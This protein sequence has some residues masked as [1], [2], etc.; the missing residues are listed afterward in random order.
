MLRM[1]S[2]QRIISS[3]I[4]R[5]SVTVCEVIRLKF[6]G[7]REDDL[8]LMAAKRKRSNLDNYEFGENYE[9]K[10]STS[11]HS[12]VS[13]EHRAMMVN[14]DGGGIETHENHAQAKGRSPTLPWVEEEDS[15]LLEAVDM[16]G[17]GNPL[18]IDWEK[19]SQHLPT[20]RSAEQCS[21]RWGS[22]LKF[23]RSEYKT[24]PWTKDEDARLEEG[25]RR[26][27]GQGLRG[28]IDWEK[29]KHDV[30]EPRTISQCRGRWNG[31]LKHNTPSIRKSPWTKEEDEL[32]IEAVRLN[33]GHGRRGATHWGMVSQHLHGLRTASQCS[34]RYVS[35]SLVTHWHFSLTSALPGC[36]LYYLC[37]PM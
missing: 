1:I 36:D 22:A 23:R 27:N 30:G 4:T 37:F 9:E 24:N 12:N 15:K 28:G 16:F 10:T 14:A 32:L 18:N 8:G 17:W 7:N 6:R 25:V 34:H 20:D 26:Y 33:E 19:V 21:R 31:I 35:N 11:Q 13:S 29:V 3:D 2:L 5:S